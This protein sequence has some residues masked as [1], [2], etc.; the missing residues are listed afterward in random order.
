VIVATSELAA[1][2]RK[3]TMVDGGFDPLHGGHIAYF[4]EARALGFPVLCNVSS[5][6]WVAHKHPPLLEQ[7][8]RAQV[9]D[10]VRWIDYVHQSQQSTAEVLG[11]LVPRYYAKGSDW[12]DRLPGEERRLCDELGIDVVFLDTVIDSSSSVIER[13]EKRRAQ[14]D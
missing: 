3:V 6:D 5:D 12:R 1:L 2:A 11:R 10:A 8:E 13:Y 7:G 14:R 4:R 9:I